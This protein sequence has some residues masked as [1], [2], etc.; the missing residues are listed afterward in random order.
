MPSIGDRTAHRFRKQLPLFSALLMVVSK[1]KLSV[2]EAIGN[3]ERRQ[4]ETETLLL[5]TWLV[6]KPEMAGGC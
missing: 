5:N 1:V 3:I 4:P 6:A 2:V